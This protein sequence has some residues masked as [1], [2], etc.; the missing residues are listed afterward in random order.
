MNKHIK[1]RVKCGLNGRTTRKKSITRT[2][3]K[4]DLTG[5]ITIFCKTV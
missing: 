5:L 4:A 1:N 3:G 2:Q